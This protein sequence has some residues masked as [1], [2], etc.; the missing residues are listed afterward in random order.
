[1]MNVQTKQFIDKYLGN[2]LLWF[3]IIFVRLLGVLLRRNHQISRP[4]NTIFVI[5]MLGLGSL[6]IASDS[7]YSLRKRYPQ[8]KLVLLTGSGVAPGIEPVG[9][10]D[11]IVVIRD[12]NWFTLIGDTIRFVLYTWRAGRTWII[13]LEVYSTLTT[14]LSSW[15]MAINRFGF[16]LDKVAFRHYLNTHHV[17][18]NRLLGVKENYQQLVKAAGVEQ[19]YDFIFP[20]Q[21][22]ESKQ[23]RYIA[24]NNT[25]SDLGGHVRKLPD[26]QLA[27][28]CNHLVEQSEIVFLGAPAD[29]I[30]IDQFI[31]THLQSHINKVINL[32]ALKLNFDAYY[33]FLKQEVKLMVTIDSAPLHIAQKLE[34]PMVS[35]WGPTMPQHLMRNAHQLEGEYYYLKKICSPCIHLT[36]RLPC[37][38]NN[39]CMKD[40][41]AKHIIQM[42]TNKLNQQK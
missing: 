14:L 26:I 1:M 5:K 11:D 6:I 8:S 42:V 32:P 36:E 34:I 35:L 19:F 17:Y 40:M 4:P 39:H 27:A 13:D 15:T 37:G 41:E 21:I 2:V 25:C 18:F 38:G 33:R 31:Q 3:H 30:A 24:I 7:I 9:L 28:L 29:A 23:A 10:F 20:Y 16:E 12:K 22:T